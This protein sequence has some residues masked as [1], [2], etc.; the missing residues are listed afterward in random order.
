MK[1]KRKNDPDF[2]M[3]A[4][5][6]LHE[7]MPVVRNLSDKSVITYKQSIYTYL[8]FLQE[9]LQIENRDVCFESFARDNIKKY[10][11]WL[12]DDKKYSPKTIALKL[13]GLKSLLKYC[14][15]EDIEL[16]SFYGTVCSLKS[17]KEAKKPIEY[18][19]PQ[20]MK[21]ILSVTDTNT[22]KHRRNRVLLIL[23]YDSG[24][25]VQEL[26]DLNVS[27]LHIVETKPFITL[28]GKGRKTRNVPLMKKTICHLQE[29]LKEFHPKM[30]EKPLFY[31][32]V[33]GKP[34]SLSTDSISLILK[35]ASDKAR[36]ECNAVPT[37]VY[38]HLIRKTRAMDL[39]QGGIPL[40]I[41]AQILGHESIS[42][43]SGFYAFATLGMMYDAMAKANKSASS[44]EMIWKTPEIEKVLYTLE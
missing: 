34:H 32:F 28:V 37:N 15:D 17:P 9:V 31:S 3:M 12:Q 42:T 35:K 29:Y 16:R 11:I 10:V 2:W 1:Y 43:T 4:R 5:T 22:S 44:E 30:E 33:D 27:S 8:E 39:Y 23:M 13:T 26:A 38:C 21:S 7:Y 18:L 24:A 19:S 36:K 25:R 6:F 20:A 40:P 41:I 14:A